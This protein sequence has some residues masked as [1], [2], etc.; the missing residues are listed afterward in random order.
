LSE[1]RVLTPKTSFLVYARDEKGDYDPLEEYLQAKQELAQAVKKVKFNP[2]L[3]Q[4]VQETL[5]RWLSKEDSRSY[6]LWLEWKV[7]LQARA[8]RK[9][10][11]RSNHSQQL[12]QASPLVTILSEDERK[13]ILMQVSELKKG[14]DLKGKVQ[15]PTK[16]LKNKSSL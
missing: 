9:V 11:G 16:E 13:H 8:W 2:I 5:S 14:V 10:L 1:S 3:L 15:I 6:G 12:R 4:Q 7:I